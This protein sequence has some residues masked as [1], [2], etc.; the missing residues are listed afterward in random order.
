MQCVIQGWI[1][2][3]EQVATEDIIGIIGKCE[4]GNIT[5]ILNCCAF[6]NIT[7]MLNFL[8]W[9]TVLCLEAMLALRKTQ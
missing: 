8:I 5:A 7:A 6:G 2:D 1:L 4:F 9:I 3:R